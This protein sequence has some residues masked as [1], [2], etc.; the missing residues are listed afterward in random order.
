[1][2]LLRRYWPALRAHLV[3]RKH[4]PPDRAED[5][6][7]SF[8]Q[9]KILERNLLQV[10]DPGRGKFRTF[11]L[12]ALDRFVIDCWRKETVTAPVGE[13]APEEGAARGPDVFDVAWAMRVLGESVRRMRTECESKRRP[14]L[15]GV[16]AGRALAPL[17]G[18]EPLPY[19]LLAD[20]CGLDSDK[21]AANPYL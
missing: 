13:P 4:V 6:V 9:E 19:K 11:L 10:A 18:T 16:F 5:L 17:Q 21:Q 8:I 12:T 7:Q 2:E 15:W 3:Y 20:R 1:D 14:D